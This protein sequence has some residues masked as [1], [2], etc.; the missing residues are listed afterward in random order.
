MSRMMQQLRKTLASLALLVMVMSKDTAQGNCVASRAG[1]QEV[2]RF[3]IQMRT[4][5]LSTSAGHSL[6]DT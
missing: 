2:G 4:M 3:D 6:R 1:K 5:A